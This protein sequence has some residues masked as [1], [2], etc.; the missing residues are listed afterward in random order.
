MTYQDGSFFGEVWV[1][2][3]APQKNPMAVVF[4]VLWSVS[5][6]N[7]PSEGFDLLVKRAC[8]P[9][10]EPSQNDTDDLPQSQRKSSTIPELSGRIGK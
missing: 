7:T 3:L 5:L 4:R 2:R 10:C 8:N 1:T 6:R 9:N